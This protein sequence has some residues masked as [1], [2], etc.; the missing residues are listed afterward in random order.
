MK[1]ISKNEL[2]ASEF[3]VETSPINRASILDWRLFN[4][5]MYS[6]NRSWKEISD[7]AEQNYNQTIDVRPYMI[8]HP[9]CCFTTDDLQKVLD[10]FR[11]MQLRQL[12][13]IN[14]RDGR[15]KGVISREDLFKYMH[16]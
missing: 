11:Y 14:P 4:T 8:E 6:T 9:H 3:D 5:D 15:L 2:G 10:I 7:V 12:C 13:V 16:I 1:K